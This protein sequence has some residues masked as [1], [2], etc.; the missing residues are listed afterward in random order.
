MTT[1]TSTLL[2]FAIAA[3]SA[4][5]LEALPSS[6]ADLAALT[7]RVGPRE[8]LRICSSSP[9][10]FARITTG[11][12]TGEPDWLE[13]ARPLLNEADGFVATELLASLSLALE[14]S[15]RTTLEALE[16]SS[17]ALN[18]VKA[19]CSAGA[20]A[21]FDESGVK[22]QAWSRTVRQ[23]LM[24]VEDGALLQKKAICLTNLW[25]PQQR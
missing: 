7:K 23:K 11:V 19:V 9:A 8:A 13:A 1:R 20:L 12:S 21:A 25:R 24:K 22:L 3:G 14:A 17:T 5:A 18:S 4:C 10:S 16:V 6:A 15:P 2:A